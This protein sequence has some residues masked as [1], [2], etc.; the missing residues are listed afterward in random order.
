MFGRRTEG[1]LDARIAE[2]SAR[3]A[4]IDTGLP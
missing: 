4:K 1:G 2:L 3:R